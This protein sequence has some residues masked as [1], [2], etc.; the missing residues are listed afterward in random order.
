MPRCEGRNT[1]GKRCSRTVAKGVHYCSTH[2]ESCQDKHSLDDASLE[3]FEEALDDIMTE[4]SKEA[5]MMDVVLPF[6]VPGSPN[7]STWTPDTDDLMKMI[8]DL[9]ARNLELEKQT[10]DQAGKMVT[11]ENKFND[12]ALNFQ[13]FEMENKKLIQ[14]INTLKKENMLL[15]EAQDKMTTQTEYA[16]KIDELENTI[17]SLKEKVQ[18]LELENDKLKSDKPTKKDSKAKRTPKDIE[19]LAKFVLYQR[20]KKDD[21]LIT[22]IRSKLADAKVPIKKNAKGEESIPWMIIKQ[23]TDIR[24]EQLTDDQKSELRNATK[25]KYGLA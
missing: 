14:V 23:Y 15:T 11:M 1:D 24:Y 2:K 13:T 10:A 17:I 6:P 12:Q 21:N 19:Y 18:A 5:A 25:A 7:T 3:V 4:I 20:L 16:T 22:D 8:D 9:K